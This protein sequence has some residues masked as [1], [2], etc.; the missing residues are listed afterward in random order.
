MTGAGQD[1]AAWG[2]YLR[3]FQI[4]ERL[5]HVTLDASFNPLIYILK[6][7]ISNL[8]A[9]FED[10]ELSGFTEPIAIDLHSELN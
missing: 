10:Q 6:L 5:V 7:N 3:G 4:T 2:A 1:A 8:L 9:A